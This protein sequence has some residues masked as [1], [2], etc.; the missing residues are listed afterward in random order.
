MSWSTTGNVHRFLA[1][2]GG[3]LRARPVEH[4]VLLT[5]AAYLQARPGTAADQ[6]FGWWRDAKGAVAGAFLRAPR[7]A[8]VL[9]P[10]PA[11]AVESLTESLSKAEAVEADAETAE[12]VAVAWKQRLGR[13]LAEL[14]R[15]TLYRLE[16]FVA[17]DQPRGRARVAAPSDREVLLHWYK[18]L[19]KGVPE[20]PSEAEYVVDDPIGFGGITLWEVDGEPVAMA[21]RSRLVAGMV[22]LGAV[23]APGDVDSYADTY[24]NAAFVAACRAARELADH[25]LVFA[26]SGNHETAERFA[27][28]GFRPVLERVMLG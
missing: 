7:H 25:V 4:T 11:E 26:P 19:M 20:D 8:P 24:A 16:H 13:E 18:M 22:R 2:A 15:I 3:F 9:S 6:E 1:E 12:T 21:G 23:Y 17:P 5:E 28:L 14:S 27:A 10:M